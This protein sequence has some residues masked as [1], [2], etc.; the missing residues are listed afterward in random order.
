MSRH[1]DQNGR[2]TE[3][4]CQKNQGNDLDRLF[5]DGDNDDIDGEDN[6]RREDE[7]SNEFHEDNK[8]HAEAERSAKIPH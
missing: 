8:L 1:N 5:D 2:K 3:D 7:C 6:C 4:E